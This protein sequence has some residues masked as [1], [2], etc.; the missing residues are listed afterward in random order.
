[1]ADEVCSLL[2]FKLSSCTSL[3]F[4]TNSCQMVTQDPLAEDTGPGVGE[5][6]GEEKVTALESQLH[7]D[8]LQSLLGPGMR[9]A[10]FV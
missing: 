8:I 6:E 3:M 4:S 1:M 10:G 5:D 2:S 7:T 9:P